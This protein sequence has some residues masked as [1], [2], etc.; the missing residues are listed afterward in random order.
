MRPNLYRSPHPPGN[1]PT[2][3]QPV[4]DMK[5]H[6]EVG[7]GWRD[8][9]GRFQAIKNYL[10]EKGG[11]DYAFSVLEVGAYNGYFCRRLHDDF[12]AECLAVDNNPR[13]EEAP[14]VRVIPKLLN[15]DAIRELGHFDV[16]M[17]M[18]VLHHR[19]DWYDFIDA[20]LKSADVIFIETAN[21]NENLGQYK[22]YAVG[23]HLELG[24]IGTVIAQTAPMYGNHLRPLWVVDRRMVKTEEEQERI[25]E[26]AL[27]MTIGP[28]ET[29]PEFAKALRQTLDD[30]GWKLTYDPA[31]TAERLRQVIA[32]AEPLKSPGEPTRTPQRLSDE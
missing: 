6:C 12:N 4:W 26:V 8:C 22:P 14:G 28:Q 13:L 27:N 16:T 9:D 18:S 21:P 3:Y 10:L 5:N 7:T 19:Q 15:P 17:C 11:H 32:T 31:Y 30:H 23:A 25:L 20:L 29:N 24:K 1:T 2:A